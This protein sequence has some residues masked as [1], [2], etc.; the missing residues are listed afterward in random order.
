MNHKSQKRGT[1]PPLR[2]VRRLVG[3]SPGGL[4]FLIY[5]RSCQLR[6]DRLSRLHSTCSIPI[7][8]MGGLLIVGK[9]ERERDREINKERKGTRRVTLCSQVQ[10]PRNSWPIGSASNVKQPEVIT[11]YKPTSKLDLA[12]FQLSD[13]LYFITLLVMIFI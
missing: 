7:T 12:L 5:Y 3:D 4:L 8:S 13:V 6:T 11:I 1:R 9:R 2:Y 10:P